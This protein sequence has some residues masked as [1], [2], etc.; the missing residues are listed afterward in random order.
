ME[1][2]LS[3]KK[4]IGVLIQFDSCHETTLFSRSITHITLHCNDL[5]YNVCARPRNISVDHMVNRSLIFTIYK[6]K[7]NNI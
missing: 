5:T 7:L 6:P 1:T 2:H 3:N 4:K